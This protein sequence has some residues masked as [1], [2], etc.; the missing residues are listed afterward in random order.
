MKTP[1]AQIHVKHPD[2]DELI[3]LSKVKFLRGEQVLTTGLW[4]E[5]D[6]EGKLQKSSALTELLKALECKSLSE[7]VGKEVETIKEADDKP[8][9]C[10]KIY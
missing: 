4:A 6:K 7:L 3:I 5:L 1:L 10:L 2:N 9:L 8:Y